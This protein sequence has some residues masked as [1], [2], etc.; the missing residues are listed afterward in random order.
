MK[1]YKINKDKKSP[2][3][4]DE[5]IMKYKNFDSLFVS[6]KDITKRQKI[7]I[8]KNKKIFLFLILLALVAYVLSKF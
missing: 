2:E 5:Q 8:Y 3:I 7:P 6:Y 4:T 1:K